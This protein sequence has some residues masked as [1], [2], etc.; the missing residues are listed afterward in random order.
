MINEGQVQFLLVIADRLHRISTLACLN[1]VFRVEVDDVVA[2]HPPYHT[3][4]TTY[5]SRAT[6]A[7][8]TYLQYV[9]PVLP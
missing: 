2:C 7:A 5:L 8:G 9:A 1:R 4:L 6:L 3:Y